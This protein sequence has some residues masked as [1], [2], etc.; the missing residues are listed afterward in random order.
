MGKEFQGEPR[1]S[2]VDGSP[3]Y[4]AIKALYLKTQAEEPPS[5]E[6]LQAELDKIDLKSVGAGLGS[7]RVL[8]VVDLIEELYMIPIMPVFEIYALARQ[9]KKGE[10]DSVTVFEQLQEL[11][12]KKVLPSGWLQLGVDEEEKEEEREEMEDEREAE[13]EEETA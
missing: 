5:E 2:L 9:W 12:L 1:K 4:D 11:H 10:M 6:E 13:E 3:V 8:A 7:G